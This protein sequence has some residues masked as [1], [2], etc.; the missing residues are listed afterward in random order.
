M[1]R[2]QQGYK[3][4]SDKVYLENIR[5][6]DKDRNI[7]EDCWRL[8]R[9]ITDLK[10]WGEGILHKISVFKKMLT[11]MTKCFNP[12]VICSGNWNLWVKWSKVG[13][14][15]EIRSRGLFVSLSYRQR[16]II[17]YIYLHSFI[18]GFYLCLCENRYICAKAFNQGSINKIH[19]FETQFQCSVKDRLEQGWWSQF[20]SLNS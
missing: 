1:C 8:N 10:G 19:A 3:E 11:W 5:I 4:E 13:R 14:Y 2:I 17:T 15:Q 16:G 18:S 9:Y 6:I 20:E 7:W 12:S